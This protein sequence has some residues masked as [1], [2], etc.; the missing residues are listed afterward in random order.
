V[1]PAEKLGLPSWL[2]PFCWSSPV[3]WFAWMFAIDAGVLMFCWW[4]LERT[5]HRQYYTS[6]TVGDTIGLPLIAFGSALVLKRIDH[7]LDGWYT[8]KWW[9]IGLFAVLTAGWMWLTFHDVHVNQ[10]QRLAPSSLWH[11]FGWSYFAFIMLAA[12]PAV[13]SNLSK[14]WWAVPAIVIGIAF[15]AVTYAKDVHTD[16]P[17]L[18]GGV[19]FSWSK[20]LKGDNPSQIRVDEWQAAG[21]PLPDWFYQYYNA[22]GTPK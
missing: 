14:M 21:K 17:P 8:N 22:D 3:G 7:R 18:G 15:W 5:W 1:S 16:P 2:P 10:A 20:L 6:N 4:V 13:L 12:A 19:E 11:T 9:F